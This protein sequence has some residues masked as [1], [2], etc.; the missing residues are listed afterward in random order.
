MIHAEYYGH[1]IKYNHRTI[2]EIDPGCFRP[3]IHDAYEIILILRGEVAYMV[4]GRKYRLKRG[5]VVFSLPSVYHDILPTDGITY[6]RHNIIVDGGA[7]PS[8]IFGLLP[9]DRDVFDTSADAVTAEL[10]DR[11]G[12]YATRL[13]GEA[14]DIAMS[15]LVCEILI[16]L[17]L[18]GKGEAEGRFQNMTVG[19]ALGYIHENLLTVRS[20]EEVCR[21]LYVTKSHLHH[22]FKE[23]IGV[24]P[25]RYIISKKLAEARRLIRRGERPTEV[26][27]KLGFGD[28]ASFYRNYRRLYGYG[29]SEELMHSARGDEMI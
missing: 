18:Y 10:F 25:K 29:P 1:G 17:S 28:Y 24:T 14:R 4:E 26:Y 21:A 13:T 6:E 20:V 8:A 9:S 27:I 22:L 11:L 19:R 3:H 2:T 15:G 16:R 5:D 7:I 12:Q 23:H